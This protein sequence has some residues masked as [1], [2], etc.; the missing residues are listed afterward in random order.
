M[1]LAADQEISQA[2]EELETAHKL[3]L[4]S[5]QTAL[6]EEKARVLSLEAV[7]AS[8]QTAHREIMEKSKDESD[9]QIEQLQTLMDAA[10]GDQVKELQDAV[11]DQHKQVSLR[12]CLLVKSCVTERL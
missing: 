5:Y 9:R 11:A 2:K 10:H 4:Q 6:E 8:L 1:N 3:E 12:I 7:Q